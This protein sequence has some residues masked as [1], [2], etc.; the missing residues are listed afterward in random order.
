MLRSEEPRME[1]VV[2]AGPL[3]RRL[4]YVS[5][6]STSE[7]VIA[8][9]ARRRGAGRGPENAAAGTGW[10]R[11]RR[12]RLP[13]CR[14]ECLEEPGDQLGHLRRADPG[15]QVEPGHRRE[16][17]VVLGDVPGAG[18]VVE[19]ERRGELVQLVDHRVEVAG[20]VMLEA[21]AVGD[22][23]GHQRRGQAG[24]ADPEPP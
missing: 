6:K 21:V 19:V 2:M 5:K 4:P 16:Q 10:S 1:S 8:R 17:A 22:D 3:V 14:A 9:A 12:R 18:D 7:S 15:G 23:R 24:P 11:P 20:A 13:L